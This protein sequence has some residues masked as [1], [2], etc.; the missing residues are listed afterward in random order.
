VGASLV[1]QAKFSETSS[2]NASLAFP[3]NHR[4]KNPKIADPLDARSAEPGQI[5]RKLAFLRINSRQ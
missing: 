1:E 5:A 4:P 2:V 3:V